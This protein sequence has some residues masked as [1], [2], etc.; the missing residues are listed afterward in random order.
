MPKYG[1]NEEPGKPCHPCQRDHLRDSE[2]DQR[3]S[4]RSTNRGS[5]GSRS[6]DPTETAGSDQRIDPPP[7]DDGWSWRS[8][9]RMS[10]STNNSALSAAWEE[11]FYDVKLC[12]INWGRNFFETS[13][14]WKINK[15]LSWTRSKIFVR[16]KKMTFWIFPFSLSFLS[17]QPFSM[18]LHQF[19]PR[20]QRFH[21]LVAKLWL[22]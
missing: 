21:L 5:R 14:E 20:W 9:W 18:C 3:R 22:C 12:S 10:S 2:R 19:A 15:Q 16:C 8:G 7:T 17:W 1:V 6:G 4:G 11:A 13:V